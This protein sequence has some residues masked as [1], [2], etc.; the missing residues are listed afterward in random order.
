MTEKRPPT[1]TVAVEAGTGV[2]MR[3]VGSI[4]SCGSSTCWHLAKGVGGATYES[5]NGS[6]WRRH[7]LCSLGSHLL[8]RIGTDPLSVYKISKYKATHRRLNV[9]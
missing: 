6:E 7:R 3:V 1:I 5:P 2:D 9:N 8:V 4:H